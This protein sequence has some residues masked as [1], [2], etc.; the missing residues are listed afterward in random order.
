MSG[1]DAL[2]AD[3]LDVGVVQRH[4]VRTLL[5]SQAFGAVGVTIGVTT[6]SLLARD[7]TG[8]T[9]VDVYASFFRTAGFEAEVDAVNTAWTAGDR[10]SAVR[11]ISPRVLDGLGV[12]GNEAFC[13]GRIAEFARAG[14]TMPV[15]LPFTATGAEPRASL[16]RTLRAFG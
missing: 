4:T 1:P 5:V 7:I 12:V 13:R 15:V 16:L 2:V 10:A 3:D 8:Y 6:S 9:I 11:H 14:L